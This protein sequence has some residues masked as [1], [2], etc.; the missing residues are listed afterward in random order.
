LKQRDSA[1]ASIAPT[2]EWILLALQLE[3]N[4]SYA[5]GTISDFGQHIFV[6]ARGGE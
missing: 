4:P 2:L 3:T 1:S 6:S 5:S